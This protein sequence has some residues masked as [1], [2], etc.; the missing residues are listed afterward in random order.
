MEPLPAVI[1]EH[2]VD[3]VAE[4]SRNVRGG[5]GVPQPEQRRQGLALELVKA[6]GE[7]NREP[8]KLVIA[9]CTQ[10]G[11]RQMSEPLTH[12]FERFVA[13]RDPSQ[14]PGT[15]VTDTCDLSTLHR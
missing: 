4:I 13:G 12:H 14:G 8:C 6:V 2:P 11:L 15:A 9:W 3:H 1:V 5:A 7:V 10:L